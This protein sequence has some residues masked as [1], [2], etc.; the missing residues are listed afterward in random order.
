VGTSE[1]PRPPA[2]RAREK[3]GPSSQGSPARSPTWNRGCDLESQVRSPPTPA[4]TGRRQSLV[5]R[6]PPPSG[7]AGQG[8]S[9][10]SAAPELAA[11]LPSNQP[12]RFKG[13]GARWQLAHRRP[14]AACPAKL[15]WSTEHARCGLGLA[16]NR[17]SSG[18]G[19]V[20]VGR[21]ET[22]RGD[23]AHKRGVITEGL[24]DSQSRPGH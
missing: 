7:R 4:T 10:C 6:W 13:T 15:G 11:P 12:D 20:R 18:G 23:P 5:R 19:R 8:Q 2:P 3:S 17:S 24:G 14:R 9:L 1:A 21:G 16:R 22:L